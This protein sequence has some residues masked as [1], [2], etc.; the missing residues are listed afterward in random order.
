MQREHSR[1]FAKFVTA[2][3]RFDTGIT[4][5]F[6]QAGCQARAWHR[7]HSWGC[8]EAAVRSRRARLDRPHEHRA[9]ARPAAARRTPR[10]GR[11]R[12]RADRASALAHAGAPRRL[13]TLLHRARPPRGR[14]PRRKGARGRL[15]HPAAPPL[16]ARRA[17]RLRP[18]AR[19]DRPSSRLPGP[20]HSEHDHVR[21][22]VGHASALGQ[23]PPRQPRA[24]SATRSRPSG[25]AGTAARPPKLVRYPGLK[26]EY[27]LS[28]FEPGR[29]RA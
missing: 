8:P 14:R 23:L 18:R 7:F 20:S 10:G 16:R 1:R 22:R 26:E 21:L 29:G 27:Y 13:G 5:N 2:Q 17:L 3:S 9:R 6:V 11:A 12:G 4:T 25:S 19:L 24:R 15:A 28:D